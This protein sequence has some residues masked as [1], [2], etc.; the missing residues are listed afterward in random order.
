MESLRMGVLR[1]QPGRFEE[2]LAREGSVLLNKDGEP[3][4]IAVDVRQTS[5]EDAIRLVTQIRAQLAV[6]RMRAQA[7]ARGL[8]KLEAAKIDT[9]IREARSA[10]SG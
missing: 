6:S 7:R 5:L 9:A 2:A 10:R 4:A 8:D 1:N 3:L